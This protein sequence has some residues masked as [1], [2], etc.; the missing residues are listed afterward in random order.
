[1]NVRKLLAYT[2]LL[3]VFGGNAYAT[4]YT[5]PPTP[6]DTVITQ[7]PDGMAI[8]RADHDET[9]LDFARKFLLGQT[10]VVRLNQDVDRWNVKKGEIV[11]LSNRR[12]LPD[13]PHEGITLNISEYRM[14]YYPADRPGT[15]MSFAHGV[16]RQDWKTPLGKTTIAR[17]VKDPAWHPPESIRREHAANGDP[18]PE[19]V[20]PGPHNPLGAYALHLNLPGEYR[21][22]GTDIDKIYGI[23][24]QITHG[25]VRMYPEDIEQLYNSAPVGT[26]VYLV[27]QPVKVGWL[28]NVL[29]IEAHPDLEGEEMTQDQRYAVALQLIQKANNGEIPDFD[30]TVLNDVLTKLDGDP[31]ALYERLPP[32]E[33]FRPEATPPVAMP[34]AVKPAPIKPL[35]A[36][37]VAVPAKPLL[38]K[39]AKANPVIPAKASKAASVKPVKTKVAVVK[40]ASAKS[41]TGKALAVAKPAKSKPTSGKAVAVKQAQ[42]RKGSATG[43]YRGS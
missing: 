8:S 13:T 17:K 9:L 18:L 39:Q 19:T 4:T 31:V 21:I 3:S 28:N 14:Y 36:K 5:L 29:Y 22:H 23:G 10:E 42:P 15:V 30:Q 7:Y 35:S 25:C 26:S 20:L 38:V 33:E 27:K 41:A 11:R 2:L 24:M 1:M 12:I 43:Y 16:G 34:V 32:L 37:P 40:P 6:G